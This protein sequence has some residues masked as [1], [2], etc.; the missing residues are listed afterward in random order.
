MGLEAL[1]SCYFKTTSP[2]FMKFTELIQWTIES[3]YINFHV[4]LRKIFDLVK[5][6]DFAKLAC[7]TL[8]WSCK[9]GCPNTMTNKTGTRN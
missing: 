1:T 2:I 9:I 7:S 4:I 3:L 8:L 5:S 6:L